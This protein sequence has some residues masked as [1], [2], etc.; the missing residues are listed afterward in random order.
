MP[1]FQE[2]FI[3]E[4]NAF[5]EGIDIVLSQQGHRIAFMSKVIGISKRSLSTY[6]KEMLAIIQA[7]QT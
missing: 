5:A 4:I 1:N 7:V 3:I 6:A 2:P